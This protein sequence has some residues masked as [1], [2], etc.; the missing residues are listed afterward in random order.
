[1]ILATGTEHVIAPDMRNV[2][3][4]VFALDVRIVTD[5]SPGSD[6]AAPCNT[7]DGCAAT[8]AS[9]CVSNG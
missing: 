2:T 7:D 5:I 6:A 4:D 3:E 1:M 8:C 9:S